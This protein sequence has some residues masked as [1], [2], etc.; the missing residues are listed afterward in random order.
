M[1]ELDKLQQ[2][3]QQQA[4]ELDYLQNINNFFRFIG[5]MTYDMRKSGAKITLLVDGFGRSPELELKTKEFNHLFG[6][7]RSELIDIME[8]KLIDM[9]VA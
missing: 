8:S 4:K 6:A 1:S 3:L 9:R 5:E 2:E 7:I